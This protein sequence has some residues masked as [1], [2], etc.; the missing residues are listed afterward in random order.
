MA[1]GCAW[2]ACIPTRQVGSVEV[3]REALESLPS[4]GAG[5]PWVLVGDFNATLDHVGVP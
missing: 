4:T 5:T 3:W 1:A 2:S